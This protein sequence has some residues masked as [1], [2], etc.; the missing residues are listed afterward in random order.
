MLKF[1]IGHESDEGVLWKKILGDK[2]H[3]VFIHGGG[4]TRHHHDNPGNYRMYIFIHGLL[5][6]N[7]VM[8]FVAQVL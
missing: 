7:F 8:I 2:S 3:Q 1:C 5:F 4:S 6:A